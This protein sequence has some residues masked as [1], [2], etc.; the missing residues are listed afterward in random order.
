MARVKVP[1]VVIN[2]STGLPV[3]GASVALSYRGAG[4]AAPWYPT[5]SGG[6]SSTSAIAT[7]ASGRVGAWVDRGAYSATISGTGITTYTE[8]FD[9]ATSSDA[10]VDPKW[11]DPAVLI[12]GEVKQYAGSTAPAGWLICDGAPV[13]RGTYTALFAAIGTA[14]GVGDGSTT[15]NLPDFRGRS[16]VGA[17]T[18]TGLTAR[19]RGQTGGEET[20]LLLAAESGVNGNGVTPSGGAH[21]HTQHVVIIS[22]PGGS[23]SGLIAYEG[24]GHQ[25]DGFAAIDTTAS[26]HSHTLTARNADSAHNV[27]HPFV[28]VNFIIKT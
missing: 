14:Y 4:G 6:T 20:H 13:L 8:S 11:M 23:I 9:A 28:V 5:E 1:I 24:T 3:N 7:D 26:A 12:P 22:S 2:S 25:F 27:M 10:S 17:G 18:G 15:F 16:P 21:G 19:T